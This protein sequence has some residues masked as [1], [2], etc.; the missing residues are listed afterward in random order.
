M[1]LADCQPSKSRVP[2][3]PRHY[4][5]SGADLRSASEGI[6]W[7][8]IR[9]GGRN[10]RFRNRQTGGLPHGLC[11]AASRCGHGGGIKIR[12]RVPEFWLRLAV[13]MRNPGVPLLGL[14][15]ASLAFPCRAAEFFVSPQGRPDNPGTSLR[16]F[17]ILEQARDA[18]RNLKQAGP[19]TEPVEIIVRA[20][21]YELEQPLVLGPEDSG[22]AK[23]PITYRAVTGEKVVVSGGRRILG[24]WK[25]VDGKIWE[26]EVPDTKTPATRTDNSPAADPAERGAWNFRQLFVDGRREIR[27]RFPNADAPNPFLYP[28]APGRNAIQLAP[29][30]VKAA[31]GKARDAQVNLVNDNKYTS[32]ISEMTSVDADRSLIRL[33]PRELLGSISTNSWFWIEGVREELDQ[34]REWF[35]DTAAGRLYYWPEAGKDLSQQEIIAPRLNALIVLKGDVNAGTH[36]EHVQFRGLEFQHTTYSLGLIEPRTHTYAALRL[37]NACFCR[38]ENCSFRNLGGYAIWLHLDSCDNT[39]D[40]NEVAFA[41]SGGLLMTSAMLGYGGVSKI[42]TPGANAA[43]AAPLRNR[44]TYNHIHDCGSIRSYCAGI[45]MDSRPACTANEP[46]NYLAHNYLHDLSRN[47][48]FGF[49]NQGGHVIEY[50]RVDHVL[51]AAHDGGAIHLA[52]VDKLAAPSYILNNVVTRLIGATWTPHGMVRGIA[53]GIYLDLFTSACQVENNLTYDSSTGGA[54]ILGGDEDTFANNL[55][56]LDASRIKNW[57][58]NWRGNLAVGTVD[59]RNLFLQTAADYPC[60]AP[61]KGNYTL[62]KD[63]PRYPPG[64][65]PFDV[66][67]AGLNGNATHH[68]SPE[69]LTRE[70]IR[71]RFS[72]AGLAKVEGAF[73]RKTRRKT[74][75]DLPAEEYL[76]NEPGAIASVT[77]TLPIRQSGTYAFKVFYDSQATL[78]KDARVKVTQSQ[79]ESTILLDETKTGNWPTLG[80]YH[81]DAGQPARVT[82]TTEGAHGPVV[83]EDMA[84]VKRS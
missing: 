57:P 69:R 48:I 64:F 83:V 15:I 16:P 80:T 37:E 68:I 18:V 82:I 39:I 36:V 27:A 14:L 60:V 61:E 1:S 5:Q 76:V 24:A 49:R 55:F 71:A 62:K 47:G 81:F 46:G 4:H 31:W 74:G 8:P 53:R 56:L 19:L 2:G 70:V 9:Y 66:G 84:L 75:G 54:C 32:Q 44:V 73:V 34:P 10:R 59:E 78:A 28:T 20:G 43:K 40:H 29:G 17:S 35:L 11:I 45:H 7:M 65:V 52:T 77:F 50:N 3:A 23:N 30:A 38:I 12:P 41:G 6:L 63:Y 72:D 22:T 58:A 13:A 21:A 26:T 67:E 79:G 51:L 25:S 33:G 42:Y